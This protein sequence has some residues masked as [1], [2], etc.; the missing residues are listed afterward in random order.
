[1]SQ[2]IHS[3]N[4]GEWSEL[5]TLAYLLV[6]GGAHAADSNQNTIESIF[7]RVLEIFVAGKK[8]DF[9]IKYI[10]DSENVEIHTA[11]KPIKY[12]ERSAIEVGLVGFFKDLSKIQP[13][14]TFPLDSGTKLLELLGKSSIAASSAHHASDLDL[15]YE[16]HNSNFPSPRIGFSIKSQLGGASTL[17]NASGA[18]NFVFKV[19]KN[20]SEMDSTYPEL[21]KGAVRAN[22]KLLIDSG[23]KFEFVSIDSENFT[24][25][26]EL[27]DSSMP[28]Y[29]ANILLT[30][31]TIKSTKMSDVIDTA[32]PDIDPKST[33]KIF[34][35][36][37]LLGAVAMGMRPS[38]YWDGDVTKFKG[39]I[40][41]KVDGEVV[42]YYLYNLTD[43]Q[44]FLFKSVKFEV[45]S[46]SRHKFGEIYSENGDDFIKLN[47]QIRFS[48]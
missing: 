1:M 24:K 20:G 27:I 21:K 6:N 11:D 25:N 13:S 30:A 9:E 29:L 16:D 35:V 43:F 19:I 5:Y 31:Y 26:L 34:K 2:D 40:V 18:T 48:K 38:G 28:E 22:M 46:T 7:Y 42:I 8:S 23:Y 44:E 10:V 37:Q 17:L 36:K 14:P 4:V 41:V 33:Q 3:G 45:A 32:F 12:I 39:L 47:L 15:V